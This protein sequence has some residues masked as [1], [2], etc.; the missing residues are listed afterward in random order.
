MLVSKVNLIKDA[1]IHAHII[2][3]IH[4]K[5]FTEIYDYQQLAHNMGVSINFSL[6]TDVSALS[7]DTSDLI[8]SPAQLKQLGNMIIS[9]ANHEKTID[10]K[11]MPVN[12]NLGVKKNCGAGIKLLSIAA[13]G[14]VFPCHMFHNTD[15]VMGNIF[16]Q[17]LS[18][19]LNSEVGLLMKGLC[20]DDFSNCFSCKYKYLCGGGCRARSYYAFRQLN[21]PDAYCPMIKEFFSTYELQLKTRYA[22]SERR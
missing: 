6:L 19:I 13:N 4:A 10:I 15:L 21:A 22:A 3:T 9:P 7:G 5:N 16:K 1:G 18:R 8:P 20:V 17:D 2:P 14:D 12:Q 11:D